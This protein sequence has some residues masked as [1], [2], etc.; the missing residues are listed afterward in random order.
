M[1]LHRVPGE[2]PT[3]HVALPEISSES[4]LPIGTRITDIDS[5]EA[6]NTLF[7]AQSLA[8][9]RKIRPG[10]DEAEDVRSIELLH[11]SSAYEDDLFDNSWDPGASKAEAHVVIPYT[12]PSILWIRDIEIDEGVATRQSYGLVRRHVPTPTG[13][14]A[15]LW[16]VANV[17]LEAPDSRDATF[18]RAR[19]AF[20]KPTI[21]ESEEHLQA[22]IHS[23]RRARTSAAHI[24]G[25]IAL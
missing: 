20:I 8:M 19:K 23:N 25:R 16:T 10:N 3:R 12:P 21:L 13:S 22:K 2:F 9:I 15:I 1:R 4:V 6:L 11:N 18:L 17:W 24:I 7:I 5:P 14:A